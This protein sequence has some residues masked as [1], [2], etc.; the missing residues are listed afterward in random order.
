MNNFTRD[1]LN[2][3][4]LAVPLYAALMWW[5]IVTLRRQKAE[6]RDVLGYDRRDARASILLGLVSL[7]TVGVLNALVKALADWLWQ[8][9]LV[10]LGTGLL[11]WAAALVAWDFAYYWF[12]RTEHETRFLWSEHVNHHSSE[13]YNLSTALRQPWTPIGV[14]VFFPPLTL[15]GVR[16]W[17]IM[18]SGGFNLVYQYWI[19][20]EAIDRLPRWFEFTFNT[21]SHHRVHHGSQSQYLDRNHGGVLIVWDRLFG[22]FEQ[23]GERV[24]YGLTKNIHTYNLWKIFNHEVVAIVHDVARAETTGDR[25]RYIFAAPGWSPTRHDDD[26]DGER[27][28]SISHARI[29]MDR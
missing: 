27:S 13:R 7:V 25:L 4:T 21:P 2:P 3:A 18:F 28:G 17:M 11:G 16:P 6:G 23:E 1:L 10:D 22:T 5:E 24:R 14:L 15:L 12:H 19:H 29:P 26:T 9:R 8:W 20:T